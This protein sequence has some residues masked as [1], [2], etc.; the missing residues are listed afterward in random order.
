MYKLDD[1]WANMLD[2]KDKYMYFGP[3]LYA[4]L[5][6]QKK[7]KTK[8]TRTQTNLSIY[9]RLRIKPNVAITLLFYL[10]IF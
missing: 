2:L 8:Q 5:P 7:Q 9:P 1:L 10:F 3:V 6:F 4:S